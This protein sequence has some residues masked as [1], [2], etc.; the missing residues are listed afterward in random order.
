L[1]SIHDFQEVITSLSEHYRVIAFDRPCH[2]RS[3]HTDTLSYHLMADFASQFIEKLHLD[4]AYV[5]GWSDGGNTALL[6]AS[7]QPEKVK[8]LIVCGADMNTEN[9]G[10]QAPE[11][12]TKIT[13][14]FV[15]NNWQEWLAN[16]LSL[17]PQKDKW[18][19]FISNTVKMWLQIDYITR[20]E[21]SKLTCK[22]L[23]VLGDRDIVIPEVGI[24]MCR[25]IKNSQLCIL[26]NTSHFIFSENP[27]L[28]SKIILNFLKE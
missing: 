10:S 26:P 28:M 5:L 6:L 17:T 2:G 1:Q 23:V 13:P 9:T 27:E 25:L 3:E 21:L 22:T 12:I 4:S 14:E 19:N 20:G 16:Y 24:K 15:E 11:N 8:K 18:K 7:M